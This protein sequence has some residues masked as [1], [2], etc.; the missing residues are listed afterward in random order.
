MGMLPFTHLA[1]QVAYKCWVVSGRWMGALEGRLGGAESEFSVRLWPSP[2]KTKYI[3]QVSGSC[4]ISTIL[5]ITDTNDKILSLLL[6]L[7]IPLI[8]LMLFFL[9]IYRISLN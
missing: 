7:F 1:L 5:G 2:S 6:I 8:S 3:L 4:K 9:K